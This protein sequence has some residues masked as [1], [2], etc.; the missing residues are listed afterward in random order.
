MSVFPPKAGF[1]NKSVYPT[2]TIMDGGLDAIHVGGPFS[3]V[4]DKFDRLV[5][6]WKD[7]STW[8]PKKGK[9]GEGKVS[10]PPE[11]GASGLRLPRDYR[12]SIGTADMGAFYDAMGRLHG[13]RVS[14][15]PYREMDGDFVGKY[16]GGRI[17]VAN[18][19]GERNLS[20][21]EKRAVTYHELGHHYAGENERD[22]HGKGADI[23]LKYG[24]TAAYEELMRMIEASPRYLGYSMN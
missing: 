7:F 6:T 2:K 18:D 21:D 12:G 16:L 22:A 11:L 24:D 17:L 13:I 4:Y 14:E 8:G 9:N 1:G 23:A 20:S 10:P 3:W 15:V 19:N 5:D